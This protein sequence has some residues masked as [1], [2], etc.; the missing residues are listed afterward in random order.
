MIF[1][2]FLGTLHNISIYVYEFLLNVPVSNSY[3]LAFNNMIVNNYC[4]NPNV[5]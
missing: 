4:V 1:I 2:Q 3:Y 5:R